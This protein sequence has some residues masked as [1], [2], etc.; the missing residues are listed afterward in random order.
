[1]EFGDPYEDNEIELKFIE[2][3]L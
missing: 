3:P 1:M 2:P